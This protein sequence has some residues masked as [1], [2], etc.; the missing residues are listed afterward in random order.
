MHYSSEQEIQHLVEQFNN[1]TLPK[2]EWTHAAHLTVGLWHVHN[3]AL[4]EAI[5]RMRSRIISYNLAIGTENTGDSG[6][7]ETLT[8]FWLTVLNHFLKLQEGKS[9]LT[10]CNELLDSKLAVNSLPFFFYDRERILST[11]ARARFQ[12]PNK[13]EVIRSIIIRILA[14]ETDIT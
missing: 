8:I 3:F 14:N 1:K 12:E 9:L 7:H 4:D 13:N 2:S 10:L 5:C 6:Y 11:N